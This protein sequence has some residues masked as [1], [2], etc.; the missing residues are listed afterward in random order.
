[1]TQVLLVTGDET[2]FSYMCSVF[3]EK[4]MKTVCVHS[5]SEALSTAAGRGFDLIVADEHLP[6]MT[7]LELAAKTLSEN[8]FTHFAVV[9]TLSDGEF[10]ESSE[11]MGILMQLS[12]SPGKEE[13]EELVNHLNRVLLLTHKIN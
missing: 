3:A 1:M 9:S 10:H 8:P 7:G 13:A 11:G 4:E 6:D 2:H 5:G 12:P